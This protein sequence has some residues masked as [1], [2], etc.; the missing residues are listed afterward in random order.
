MD[1]RYYRWIIIAN[2]DGICSETGKSFKEG[3]KILYEKGIKGVCRA[4]TY[5]ESSQYY[6][7]SFNDIRTA[8]NY[9]IVND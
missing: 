3:E 6:K 1:L 9:L 7:E 2:R 5:C 8:H 4:R